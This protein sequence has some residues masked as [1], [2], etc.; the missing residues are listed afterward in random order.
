MFSKSEGFFLL[1][2]PFSSSAVSCH[3]HIS[4]AFVKQEENL[5]NNLCLVCTCAL[6]T[7]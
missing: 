1:L 5:L 3:L 6:L 7:H 4:A 2:P